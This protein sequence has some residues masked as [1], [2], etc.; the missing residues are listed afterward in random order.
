VNKKQSKAVKKG[1]REAGQ[2]YWTDEMSAILKKKNRE[3][4]AYR[5]GFLASLAF[6][7]FVAVLYARAF[8]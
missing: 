8:W 7:L 5:S 6:A 1:Y 4:I 3:L 2:L